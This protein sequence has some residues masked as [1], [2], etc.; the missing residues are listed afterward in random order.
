M[1]M[2]VKALSEADYASW[3]EDQKEPA[4]SP[5]PTRP[6]SEGLET[7]ISQC[8]SCHQIGGVNGHD[9]EPMPE[10]ATVDDP[11]YDPEVEL[12]PTA[13]RRAGTARRRCRDRARTSPTS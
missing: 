9:C 7:S 12:P 6:P 10:D 3:L 1:R 11:N 13:S 8:S 2:A 5:E 4:R